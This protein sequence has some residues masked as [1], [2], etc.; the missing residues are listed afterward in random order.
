MQIIL[1]PSLVA[2]AIGSGLVAGIFFAFS[3]FVM[4]ALN[5]QPPASA[6]ATM[7][8]VNVVVINRGFLAAFVGT[9]LGSGLVIALGALR[10]QETSSKLAIAAALTYLIGTFAVTV[11]GNIPLNDS[12]AAGCEW[13]AYYGPWMTWN[14]VRTAAAFAAAALMTIA[15]LL[16]G[17]K[18]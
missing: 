16:E 5:R 13:H 14:H 2:A 6:I 18:S 11:R 7:Q 12:L 4:P 3:N 1:I 15:L 9:A 17:A 10:W 8:A